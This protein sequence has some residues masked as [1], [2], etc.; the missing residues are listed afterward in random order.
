[1][2][3][4]KKE[5]KRRWRRGDEDSSRNRRRSPRTTRASPGATRR[6]RQTERQVSP[7]FKCPPKENVFSQSSTCL[8]KETYSRHLHLKQKKKKSQGEKKK[9]GE[10]EEEEEIKDRS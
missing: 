2:K 3:E 1:M 8:E 7:R 6:L 9:N 5:R 4:G 10:E